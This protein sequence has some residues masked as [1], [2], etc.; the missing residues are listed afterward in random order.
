MMRPRATSEPRT[1]SRYSCESMP[2]SSWMRTAGITIPRSPAI[3]RRI[4]LTR[5]SRAP[6]EL[7]STSG[8]RPKPTASSSASTESRC[9]ASSELRAPAGQRGG[10]GGRS[11]GRV[12]VLV[13]GEAVAHGP[14]DRAEDAGDHQE[15]QLRQAGDE[16]EQADRGGRDERRLAL[17]QDLPGD[18]AAEVL[19]GVRARHDDAGRDRDQQRGDLR[20][21]AVADGQQ[22]ELVGRFGEGHVALEHPDDDAA[23]EVDRG[24]DHRGHRVAFD[25]LRGAVHR[26]VEVGFLGDLDRAACEPARR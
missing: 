12:G 1:F 16:R 3:W 17:A 23:D 4:M 10:R 21:E 20:G 6:L 13:A 19:A 24:D 11:E 2:I 25:E 15:G 5:R 26:P 22:R 7:S 8:T 18:V 14:A 9:I